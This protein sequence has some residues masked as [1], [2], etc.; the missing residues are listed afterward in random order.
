MR[1]FVLAATAAAIAVA[2]DAKAADLPST[3]TAPP[4]LVEPFSWQ[5]FYL[6]AH[7]GTAWVYDDS[8]NILYGSAIGAS[9]SF[10]TAGVIGGLHLG[11][12]WVFKSWV[13]GLE[14][15]VDL[16]S[17]E[18]TVA[19]RPGTLFL[20]STSRSPVQGSI[21][22]RVGYAFDR[23]LI[24][25][26]GGGEFAGILNKYNEFP[27]GDSF[28]QTRQSWTVGGGVEYA[29]NKNWS[30]RGEYRY[31][32]LGRY[33][34]GPVRAPLYQQTHHWEESQVRLG[35]SWK[36]AHSGTQ[37]SLAAVR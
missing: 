29:L 36:Y 28:S 4:P 23:T 18:G 14:G 33:F 13:F 16:T 15:D 10:N 9:S 31:A 32:D 20:S 5:G 37:S 3:K 34:D 27:T 30:V 35:F 19:S 12:N 25:V 8:S 21:R 24:Y 1:L 6:G 2:A 11:Y 17:L 22:G 7:A 26:T